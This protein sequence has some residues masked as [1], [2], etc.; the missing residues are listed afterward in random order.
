M[1]AMGG[2]LTA[3]SFFEASE[4]RDVVFV[5]YSN[6]TS[7]TLPTVA[8]HRCLAFR[9]AT[10]RFSHAFFRTASERRAA[11]HN[12]NFLSSHQPTAMGTTRAS[13]CR[14]NHVRRNLWKLGARPALGLSALLHRTGHL[15]PGSVSLAQSTP[16]C[17]ACCPLL[18]HQPPKKK[19][20]RA[21]R[22]C[23]SRLATRVQLR[24]V[25]RCCC[26]HGSGKLR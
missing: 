24:A 13:F 20:L 16:S 6:G 11:I 17:C 1:K 21:P 15:T 25:C 2:V 22:R 18:L 8:R 10:P 3:P 9:P 4:W 7:R 26:E 19:R 5:Y 14:R 12:R 23:T